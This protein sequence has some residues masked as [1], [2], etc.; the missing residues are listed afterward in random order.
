LLRIYFNARKKQLICHIKCIHILVK[1]KVTPVIK[2][3]QW[4]KFLTIN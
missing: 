4:L 1:N 2:N 3:D